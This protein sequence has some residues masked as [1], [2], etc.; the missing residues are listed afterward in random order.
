MNMQAALRISLAGSLRTHARAL[1]EAFGS[2]DEALGSDF[3][4]W[5]EAGVNRPQLYAKATSEELGRK[6]SQ[7]EADTRAIGAGLIS[8]EDD[9]FPTLL[10]QVHDPPPVLFFKGN[11]RALHGPTVAIV[12][13]RKASEGSLAFANG[14]AYDLATAGATIVSG[15][16]VGVDA[17]A[18]RA[19]VAAA[20]VGVAVLAHG[21]DMVYPERHEPLAQALLERGCLVSEW[22]PG[23]P[24]QS[25]LFV[26]RNRLVMGLSHCL[27]II[28]AGVR[29]GALSTANFALEAGREIYVMPA[30]PNEERFR[31][32]IELLRDGAHMLLDAAS[33]A[34]SLPLSREVASEATG[35]LDRLLRAGSTVE[36][37]TASLGRP[38]LEIMR[39]LGWLEVSGKIRR[40]RDGRFYLT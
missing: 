9:D 27:A 7:V 12:G 5:R 34:D 29:S 26:A 40:G 32:T 10:K 8:L 16:A 23:V 19:T 13:A 31:G 33:I 39:E 22:Q 2:F 38:Q 28:E 35:D 25:H 17:Q 15:L 37:L 6:V 4:S 21:L 30:R 20:G 18:H 11:S 14:V 24:P 3:S 1:L 36:E